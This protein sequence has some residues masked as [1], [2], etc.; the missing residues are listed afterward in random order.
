MKNALLALTLLLA[1]SQADAATS[2][3]ARVDPAKKAAA[4]PQEQT[5]C[6]AGQAAACLEAP[7]QGAPKSRGRAIHPSGSAPSAPSRGTGVASKRG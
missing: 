3:A 5:Y 6:E 4:A 1:A 2:R 7:A